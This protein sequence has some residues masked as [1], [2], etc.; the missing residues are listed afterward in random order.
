MRAWPLLSI[1]SYAYG[2]DA[3]DNITNY[4]T[5]AGT[6]AGT[7]NTLNELITRGIQTYHY[8]VN[9][10]LLND[11]V[12]T[13]QWDAENRLTDIS[14]MATPT[15][16]AQLKYDGLNRRLAIIETSG[17]TTTE[18]RYL[19]CVN[20]V[21]QARDATDTV[22]RRYF[23]QGEAQIQELKGP[24]S[25]LFSIGTRL[26]RADINIRAWPSCHSVKC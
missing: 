1:Q 8:D 20:E 23:P 5:P 2:Y 10:N 15:T 25:N 24:G 12:H 6:S 9:G 19:W 16:T 4:V 21:C 13:Y 26:H 17:T 3:A 11:G 14:L 7:Y 22:T 18:T